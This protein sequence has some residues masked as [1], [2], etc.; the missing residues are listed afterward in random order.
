MKRDVYNN[1]I[2][3]PPL[4]MLQVMKINKGPLDSFTH[5]TIAF[6]LSLSTGKHCILAGDALNI[7]ASS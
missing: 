1:K 5:H 7:E 6:R 4:H 3:L 2:P